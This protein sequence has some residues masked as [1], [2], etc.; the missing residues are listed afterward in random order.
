[1]AKP[2]TLYAIEDAA[3]ALQERMTGLGFAHS[4]PQYF[5]V[6]PLP[7]DGGEVVRTGPLRYTAELAAADAQNLGPN[8]GIAVLIRVAGSAEEDDADGAAYHEHIERSREE[9]A[10]NMSQDRPN[11]D[12]T[13]VSV[14]GK[15]IGNGY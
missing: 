11:W 3:L 1:M 4:V 9:I 8:A 14:R 2:T 5:A 10:A 13:P 7:A 15:G 12:P 6:V